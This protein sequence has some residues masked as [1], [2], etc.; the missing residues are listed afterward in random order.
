[1]KQ[2]KYLRQALSAIY[3]ELAKKDFAWTRLC[4]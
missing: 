1:L 2:L 3:P 4:W